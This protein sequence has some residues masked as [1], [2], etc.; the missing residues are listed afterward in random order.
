[1]PDEYYTQDLTRST[2]IYQSYPELFFPHNINMPVSVVRSE[3]FP[4]L[5]EAP[6][7]NKEKKE[8]S[9][10]SMKSELNLNSNPEQK[11]DF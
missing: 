3:R 1:M 6:K 8:G 4:L 11:I 5:K 2:S 7:E 10:K 9:A